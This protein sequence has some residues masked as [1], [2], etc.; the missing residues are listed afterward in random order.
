M[1]LIDFGLTLPPA[2][3]SLVVFTV[4]GKVSDFCDDNGDWDE[5]EFANTPPNGLVSMVIV[6]DGEADKISTSSDIGNHD[7]AVVRATI[8]ITPFDKGPVQ[9]IA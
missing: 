7:Q 4:A 2:R 6:F 5:H 9:T 8:A 1:A 3:D